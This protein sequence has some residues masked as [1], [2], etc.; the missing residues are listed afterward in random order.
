MTQS[1]IVT[2]YQD[3][4]FDAFCV[5]LPDGRRV[6]TGSYMT[7]RRIRFSHV[8]QDDAM[9]LLNHFAEAEIHEAGL[10][11]EF[12]LPTEYLS[13]VHEAYYS[14]SHAIALAHAEAERLKSIEIDRA[15]VQETESQHL[16]LVL[17]TS[18]S[19]TSK[20]YSDISRV[21]IIE[22]RTGCRCMFCIPPK[23]HLPLAPLCEES[24]RRM[25]AFLKVNPAPINVYIPF[26]HSCYQLEMIKE[27][28]LSETRP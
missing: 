11:Y 10:E 21:A 6:Y 13:G 1:T 22:K 2:N 7:Y 26:R 8:S 24:L 14:Y 4:L 28:E 25:G 16:D 17:V 5:I 12:D 23:V 9:E 3:R 27:R 20:P 18:L 19:K 15:T